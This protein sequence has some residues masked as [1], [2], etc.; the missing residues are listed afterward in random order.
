M[1]IT[2]DQVHHIAELAKLEI[3]SEETALFAAQLSEILEYVAKLGQLETQ[4]VQP[5]AHVL[6]AANVTE[7]DTVRPSLPRQDV[8]ANAPQRQEG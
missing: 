4:D 8:L 3:T 6:G 7:G 2:R 1:K 5:T